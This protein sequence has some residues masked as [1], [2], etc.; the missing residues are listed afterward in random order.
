MR[1]MLTNELWAVMEPLVPKA[2]QHKGG[3]PPVLPDRIFFE[4]R[5]DLA[6]TGIPGRD[7]PAE[8][9]AWDAVTNRFRPWVASGALARLFER[10]TTE[11]QFDDIRRVFVDST[12][13]R[14]HR[15]AA[16]AARK[17][18]ISGRRSRRDARGWGGAAAG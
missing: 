8:F 6:R 17:K 13:V 18:S 2:K 3:Q 10:M 9:G 5:L 7:L 11:P 14:S 15:H 12:I 1:S 4:A 16:G